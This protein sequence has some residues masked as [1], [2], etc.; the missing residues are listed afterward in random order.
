MWLEETSGTRINENRAQEIVASGAKTAATSCPF[1]MTMVRDGVAALG[2]KDE[3]E[4]KD[5]AEV[6]V[7]CLPDRD[8]D[9]K[10]VGRVPPA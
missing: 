9:G 3:V 1:C 8:A 2:K 4:V 6:V 7:G 10:T 5:I